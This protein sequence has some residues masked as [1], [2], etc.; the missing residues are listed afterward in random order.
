MSDA[1]RPD[2]CRLL[3]GIP[4][5]LRRDHVPG[6]A[7]GANRGGFLQRHRRP[8]PGGIPVVADRQHLHQ[9]DLRQ[10]GDQRRQSRRQLRLGGRTRLRDLL[11]VHPDRRGGYL[12]LADPGR[13]HR[14]GT[15]SDRSL[16][17]P[18]GGRLHPRHTGPALQRGLEQHRRGRRLFRIPRVGPHTARPNSP[19]PP[20]FGSTPGSTCCWWRCSRSSATRFTTRY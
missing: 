19:A 12:P 3:L 17:T 15:L 1:S 2:V 5:A 16:R 4:A 9:L 18:G 14:P 10:I 11:A 7:P 6:F 20:S 13:C 8:G